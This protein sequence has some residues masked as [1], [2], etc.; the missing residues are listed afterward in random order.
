MCEIWHALP[1]NGFGQRSRSCNGG[2]KS[3]SQLHSLWLQQVKRRN[4]LWSGSPKI[5]DVCKIL[6]ASFLLQP[7]E[8]MGDWGYTRSYFDQLN[9][10]L[11][12]SN[13]NMDNVGCY[14]DDLSEKIEFS[15]FASFQQIPLQL[16]SLWTYQNFKVHYHWHYSRY[17]L[18]LKELMS[19]IL[20]LML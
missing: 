9:H 7:E 5:P 16:Y 17:I 12:S 19:V 4:Q 14:P 13:R 15:R 11:A 2:K 20:L 8:S 6:F 3:K 10:H 18:S 1:N